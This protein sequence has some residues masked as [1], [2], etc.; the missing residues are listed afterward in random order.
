MSLGPKVSTGPL[1]WTCVGIARQREAAKAAEMAYHLFV[2][3]MV[4]HRGGEVSL[5]EGRQA[6]LGPVNDE[7]DRLKQVW[8]D[9]STLL[10]RLREAP[11]STG[12]DT[13]CVGRPVRI[14]YEGE[15]LTKRGETETFLLGGIGECD[16]DAKL[17]TYSC[18]SPLGRAV[19][20]KE[21]GDQVM[22]TP[23]GG[24]S[25]WVTIEEIFTLDDMF[26]AQAMNPCR[27]SGQV[28]M[29]LN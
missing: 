27:Q 20:R 18:D 12:G 4:L 3:D 13:V 19:C 11:K 1:V 22:V 15:M 26:V 10:A 7:R 23:P 2:K 16:T 24:D 28:S 25:Y 29:S 5:S 6:D 9:A 17:R 21:I 8:D 14:S